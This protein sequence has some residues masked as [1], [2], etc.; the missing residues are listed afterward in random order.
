MRKEGLFELLSTE[1]KNIFADQ[2][3]EMKLAEGIENAGEAVREKEHV[4]FARLL[5]FSQLRQAN[6][7]EIQ[8]QYGIRINKTE[9]NAGSGKIRIRKITARNGHVRYEMTTKSDV[10][11]GKIEVTVPTTEANFIQMKVLADSGMLKHRYVFNVKGTGLKWEID[12]V[13]DGNGGYYPWVRAEIEV[14]DLKESLPDFPLKTE[15]IIFP[16]QFS[17]ISEEEHKKKTDEL[18]KR[19]FVTGNPHLEKD[20]GNQTTDLKGDKD[21]EEEETDSEDKDTPEEVKKEKDAEASMSVENITDDKETAEK[22]EKRAEQIKEAK[23]DSDEDEEDNDQD[24]DD[25][26][27]SD[28]DDSEDEDNED[29]GSGDSSEDGEK[30]KDSSDDKEPEWEDDEGDKEVAKE[31]RQFGML[32]GLEVSAEGI[33]DT[34]KRNFKDLIKVFT[35]KPAYDGYAEIYGIAFKQKMWNG[36]GFT[37]REFLSDKELSKGLNLTKICER[38]IKDCSDKKDVSHLRNESELDDNKVYY[39]KVDGD[40]NTWKKSKEEFEK[41]I[42]P[43]EIKFI[44]SKVSEYDFD[45]TNE[46]YIKA[47]SPAKNR[48]FSSL[49]MVAI[50]NKLDRI[51]VDKPQSSNESFDPSSLDLTTEDLHSFAHFAG[52][53]LYVTQQNFNPLT[54]YNLKNITSNNVDAD[55]GDTGKNEWYKEKPTNGFSNKDGLINGFFGWFK[56]KNKSYITNNKDGM[57]SVFLAKETWFGYECFNKGGDWLNNYLKVY[58]KFYTGAIKCLDNDTE[59]WNKWVNQAQATIDKLAKDGITI[60]NHSDSLYVA[61][62]LQNITVR[63]DIATYMGALAFV[64]RNNIPLNMREYEFTIQ[65]PEMDSLKQ[66]NKLEKE[67]MY[68]TDQVLNVPML[69]Y[70]HEHPVFHILTN[71]ISTKLKCSHRDAAILLYHGVFREDTA[72]GYFM[73]IAEY[74]AINV[75][76]LLSIVSKTTTVVNPYYRSF[77]ISDYLNWAKVEDDIK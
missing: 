50:I 55:F 3:N 60:N 65:N 8:E 73:R 35:G 34:I 70:V 37:V 72:I 1:G 26:E 7:A 59:T 10:S 29:S 27:E 32:N 21:I 76:Y 15:E 20:S 48:L 40:K 74:G 58:T 77:L 16:P 13:P 17:E 31:S 54:P 53:P 41:H 12:A 14:K 28:E 30:D 68:S 75:L 24:A 56:S 38:L 57:L 64:N 6:K 4:V 19:F 36:K 66:L 51:G 43:A 9:E 49:L 46:D 33:G 23:D 69:D 11:E 42:I 63:D 25:T 39:L 71:Q 18:Y 5:D 67:V 47:V 52:Q 61:H 2:E 22:V 62:A 44:N 45:E